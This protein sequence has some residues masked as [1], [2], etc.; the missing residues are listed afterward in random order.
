[1]VQTGPSLKSAPALAADGTVYVASMDGKLYAVAPSTAA[2]PRE[3][4]VRWT[5]DFG[6]HLGS[7][8]LV[9]AAVPPPGANGIG[10][11]A[12]PTIGPD[13]TIYI[14]ANNSNFY[15]ITPAGELKWLYEAEREVAGIWSTAALSA[16]GSTLYFGANK[17]GIYA[18]NTAD[19]SRRWQ[20]KLVG[21]VYSSPTLDSRGTLY[22]GST[23]GHVLALN[24]AGEGIFDYD[25]GAP[26][27]TA[28]AIR[29][30]GS[31]VV[32]DTNGRVLLLGAE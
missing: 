10:S 27:W 31:L 20:Y 15:A 26:V 16:D 3:G 25:A 8:A 22:S 5:F 30:D 11:G 6:E 21:S 18:L 17:G 12:S 28:P 32:A 23:V 29:P 2:D 13:G 24:E 9:T 4:S 19:G 7:A 14:G 1:M